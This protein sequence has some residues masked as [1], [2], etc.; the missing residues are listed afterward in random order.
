MN[1]LEM[2]DKKNV[3]KDCITCSNH[4]LRKGVKDTLHFCKASG[5]ILLYPLYLPQNCSNF[6]LESCDS[7]TAFE[8]LATEIC[9]PLQIDIICNEL[10]EYEIDKNGCTWCEMNCGKTNNG[11]YPEMN[12]YK[13]WLEMKRE[14]EKE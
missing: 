5:K 12:C 11:E 10:S 1:F 13:K 8:L 9:I 6:V 14:H 4:V 3:T 7:M 2:L